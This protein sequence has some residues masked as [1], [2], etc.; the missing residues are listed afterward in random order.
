MRYVCAALSE[1]A[2][3]E[4]GLAM[5]DMSDHRDVAE[6]AGIECAVDRCSSSRRSRGRGEGAWEEEGGA[7][8]EEGSESRCWRSR[9]R[10]ATGR[11][12]RAEQHRTR[13]FVGRND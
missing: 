10:F 5:V 7:S 9:V 11:P 3:H 12:E 13:H 1:Q 2:V 8:R 4:S 6:P